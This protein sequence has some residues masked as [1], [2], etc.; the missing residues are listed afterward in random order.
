MFLVIHL[1]LISHGRAEGLCSLLYICKRF[2]MGE[3]KACFPSYT[4]VPDF[5]W[6]S[7]RPVFLVIHLYPD[8][9]WESRRPVFLVIHLY[10]ISHGREEGLCSLLYICT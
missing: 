2:L 8:F 4:F 7:R 1:Y 5:S 6:E 10:L 9:S 3:Q